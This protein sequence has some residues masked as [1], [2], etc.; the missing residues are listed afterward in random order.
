MLKRR[1]EECENRLNAVTETLSSVVLF[2]SPAEPEALQ[3]YR[4]QFK[5]LDH[6]I[7]KL[8]LILLVHPLVKTSIQEELGNVLKFVDS[9]E[10]KAGTGS[11]TEN[12]DAPANIEP[13]KAQ[14]NPE[15]KVELND[16]H[17]KVI[18]DARRIIA[19]LEEEERKAA[20]AAKIEEQKAAEAL[21]NAPPKEEPKGKDAKK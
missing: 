19:E 15:I 21:A 16:S 12:L 4:N 20:E 11:I 13:E 17:R 7:H 1:E 10:N 6:V 9:L 2:S 18:D 14:S 8:R 3:H 5:E